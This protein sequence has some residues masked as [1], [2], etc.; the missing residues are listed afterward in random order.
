MIPYRWGQ[1]R[2]LLVPHQLFLT[3]TL[4]SGAA[5]PLVPKAFGIRRSALASLSTPPGAREPLPYN[6]S[7]PLADTCG[8]SEEFVGRVLGAMDP[9]VVRPAM[10]RGLDQ[11]S[12]IRDISL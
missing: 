12:F 1:N 9:S 6:P 8:V 3:N 5:L 10:H 11:S 2:V 7:V 4:G